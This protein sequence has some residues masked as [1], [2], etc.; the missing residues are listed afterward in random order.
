MDPWSSATFDELVLRREGC[1]GTCPQ[2]EVEFR[3]GGA[4]RW[5][6]KAYTPR[7]GTFTGEIDPQDYAR[8]CAA[9][10]AADLV[11]LEPSYA[12]RELHPPRLVVEWAQGE[13]RGAI[14]VDGQAGPDEL[15]AFCALLDELAAQIPWRPMG[16]SRQDP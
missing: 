10:E 14:R 13:R 11:R 9:A 3:R 5:V 16:S 4:A 15:R 6:G 8:L 12:T 7:E 2:N 1:Y